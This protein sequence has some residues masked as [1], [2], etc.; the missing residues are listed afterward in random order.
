MNECYVVRI[1]MMDAMWLEFKG[2]KRWSVTGNAASRYAFH[3]IHSWLVVAIH[4]QCFCNSPM[5]NKPC[6]M[7]KV[8]VFGANHHHD[9]VNVLLG[10][11]QMATQRQWLCVL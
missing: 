2:W 7:C 4:S 8:G 10:K 5:P 9:R 6:Q 3:G 11:L 1:Q